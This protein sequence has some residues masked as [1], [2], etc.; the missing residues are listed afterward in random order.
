M[1][2]E[3]ILQLALGGTMYCPTEKHKKNFFSFFYTNADIKSASI[4][5]SLNI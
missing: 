4:L 1:Y 2:G 3:K 5:C